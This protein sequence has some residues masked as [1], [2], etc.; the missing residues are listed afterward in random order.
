MRQQS[1]IFNKEGLDNGG[2]TIKNVTSG[3]TN[4]DPGTPK[5]GLV[6]LSKP[7]SGNPTVP[8]NYSSYCR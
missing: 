4:Y 2:K 5:A 8:D 1:S 6:D 3:L 7:A